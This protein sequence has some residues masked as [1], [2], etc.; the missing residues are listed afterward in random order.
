MNSAKRRGR[1]RGEAGPTVGS[2]VWR[3]SRLQVGEHLW[4]ELTP[5]RPM[6]NAVPHKSRL[7]SHMRDWKFRQRLYMAT[8]EG[9]DRV[10]RLSKIT[11][12]E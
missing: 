1:P 3:L 4:E 12:V 5:S 8:S 6:K 2:R 11:R 7:P 9:E 10:T